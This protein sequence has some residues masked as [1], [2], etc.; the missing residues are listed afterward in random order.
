MPS[1]LTA[2]NGAKGLLSGEFAE[3]VEVANPGY[4]G[5]G[6]CD[7]CNDFPDEPETITETVPVSWTTIMAIYAMAV[8][9]FGQPV[10]SA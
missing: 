1:A 5:C 7:F 8:K 2:E 6:D 3:S 4:C 9:H 10:P